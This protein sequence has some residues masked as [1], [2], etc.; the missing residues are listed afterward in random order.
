MLKVLEK[1]GKNVDE[2]IES[3]LKELNLTRNEVNIEVLEEGSKGFLGIGSKD[4]KIR[5][6][7]KFDALRVAERFLDSIAQPMGEEVT[8]RMELD[9]EK[10]LKIE[11]IGPD[12]GIFIGRRGETLDALQY[13]TSLAVN[14]YSDDYIK[15]TLNSENYR[16]KRQETLTRLAKRLASQVMRTGRSITLEPMSPNERRIIHSTLQ[17][18]RMV[19]TYSVGDEPTRKVVISLKEKKKIVE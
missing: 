9:D 8:Y 7:E 6:T 12:M 10:H 1:Q 5:V 15:V 17:G 18:H 14:K 2:A 11:L 16:E 3:A 13:L 19:Y 4:A